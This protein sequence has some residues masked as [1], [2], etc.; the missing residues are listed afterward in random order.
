M[1]K[2]VVPHPGET[3]PGITILGAVERIDDQQGY[4]VQQRENEADVDRG[5]TREIFIIQP[6]R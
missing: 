6:L 4:W 1:P 3:L 5:E 2:F